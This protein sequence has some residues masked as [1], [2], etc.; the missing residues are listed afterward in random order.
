M[1]EVA[2][3]KFS[4][5]KSLSLAGTKLT[6]PLYSTEPNP[7]QHPSTRGDGKLRDGWC[8]KNLLT[9]LYSKKGKSARRIESNFR[10]TNDSLSHISQSLNWSL[11]SKLKFS[12]CGGPPGCQRGV[13]DRASFGATCMTASVARYMICRIR[14]FGHS[15]REGFVRNFHDHPTP[16]YSKVTH[17]KT[18]RLR[19]TEKAFTMLFPKAYT[20]E[21]VSHISVK[22]FP[23]TIL[24]YMKPKVSYL[25]DM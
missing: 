9:S 23:C 11:I 13:R 4:S 12:R 2:L 1:V 8:S 24:L 6:P 3:K 15:C 7:A 25:R 16:P 18:G 10:E 14:G 17:I 5:C 22:S 21:E 20:M 19:S